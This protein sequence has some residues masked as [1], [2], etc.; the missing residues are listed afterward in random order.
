MTIE[1]FKVLKNTFFS[2]IAFFRKVSDTIIDSKKFLKCCSAHFDMLI[3]LCKEKT[4]L[5]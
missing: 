2:R 3:D 1:I 4:F 5:V